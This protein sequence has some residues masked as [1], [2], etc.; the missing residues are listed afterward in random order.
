MIQKVLSNVFLLTLVFTLSA[1]R[2]ND[3]V[4]DDNFSEGTGG[5]TVAIPPYED[6]L[7]PLGTESGLDLTSTDTLPAKTDGQNA[8]KA[9]PDA[10]Q[11][12]RTI[13]F[14][15]DRYVIGA[16]EKG[17]LDQL[18]AYMIS[19]PNIQLLIAG[20]CSIPGSE[21]YNRGLSEKRA[22]AARDYLVAK[23][24]AAGNIETIGYGEEQPAKAGNTEDAHAANRRCDFTIGTR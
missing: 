21:E 2:S 4:I 1:C 19:N 8:F 15:H 6:T 5:T 23:G 9:L 20:H 7:T 3:P 16:S 14:A 18:A 17:K 12:F 22:L 24:V 13:Y 11:V 10:Y